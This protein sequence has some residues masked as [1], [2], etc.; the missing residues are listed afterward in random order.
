MLSPPPGRAA[1]TTCEQPAKRV[2]AKVAASRFCSLASAASAPSAG[3][4]SA[5]LSTTTS[6]SVVS[7]P[8]TRHSAVCVWMPARRAVSGGLRRR[9]RLRPQRAARPAP[10]V[11]STT[12][13]IRSMICAPPM[14]VRMSEA[15]PGQ[16]TNVTCTASKGA[17]ARCGGS[18]A[19]KEEKPRSSVMPR[20]A[21][22]GCLSSAAVD[23]VVLSAR[24]RL[25]L[26]LSTCP[27]MPTLTLSTRDADAAAAIAPR[28]SARARTQQTR[29]R[30]AGSGAC[31][32]PALSVW[33][34]LVI[35]LEHVQSST[36][37]PRV[38]VASLPDVRTPC[39]P[40]AAAGGP[41]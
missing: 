36:C 9:R 20:A 7:S 16:S 21:L 19:L 27:R 14:M 39:K 3:S 25:V 40:P 29:A 5:L 6:W 26:P 1:T 30:H 32:L 37:S 24:A 28:S 35:D 10:L 23:S 11:T 15:W 13:S 33:R 17:P 2:A 22:C 31:R 18:G 4:R 8:I 12:S 41:R 38:P 34:R